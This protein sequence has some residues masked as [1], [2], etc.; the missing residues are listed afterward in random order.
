MGEFISQSSSYVSWRSPLT[1]SLRNLRRVSLDRI[2]AYAEKENIISSN[3]ESSFLRNFFLVCEFTS[4]C[5]SLVLWKQFANTL[6]GESAKWTLGAHGVTWW[7]RK[8]PQITTR[9]ELLR[10]CFLMCDFI[11]QSS[12]LPFWEQ[13]ANTVVVNSAKWYLGAHGGLPWKRKYP[14]IKTGKKPCEK[15]HCNVWMQLTEVHVSLQW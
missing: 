10:D 2:E 8:Y 11:T 5:Y 7:N 12:T 6:F 14:Q 3:R 13:F 15:L 1:L 9:E 4:Q